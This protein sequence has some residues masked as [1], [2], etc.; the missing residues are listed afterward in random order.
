MQHN[1]KIAV[2]RCTMILCWKPS[3]CKII[4]LHSDC[5]DH[6]GNKCL[7]IL[8]HPYILVLITRYNVFMCMLCMFWMLHYNMNKQIK[9]NI[10]KSARY[11]AYLGWKMS[12]QFLPSSKR[13]EMKIIYRQVCCSFLKRLFRATFYTYL[14]VNRGQTSGMVLS[15]K[16]SKQKR[17]YLTL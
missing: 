14:P 8:C 17:P 2:R 16:C 12:Y 11:T 1:D 6:S 10:K 13:F 5:K 4:C 3:L 7:H 9:I 15:D